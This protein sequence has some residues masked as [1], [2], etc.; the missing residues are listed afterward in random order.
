MIRSAHRNFGSL[1]ILLLGL[2][3]FYSDAAKRGRQHQRELD[4]PVGFIP[5]GEAETASRASGHAEPTARGGR[6]QRARRREDDKPE[7]TTAEKPNTPLNDNL[8]LKW[9]RGKLSSLD[10]Q[11]IAYD[12]RSQCA[13]G[14]DALSG[15]GSS[16][17]H[18]QNLFR[19]LVHIFGRPAGA[20]ELDWILIPTKGN[21]R[22]PSS[23][24]LAA[25][26][27]ARLQSDRP[28]IWRKRIIGI[29]GAS[30][31]FW[32]S[33]QHSDYVRNHPHL[34]RSHWDTIVPLGMHGDG[35][36][37]NKV[38]SLYTFS[39][40]SLIC[41]GKTLDMKF[42]F[43]VIKKT[44]LVQDSLD[45]LMKA[46]AWSLNVILSGETPHVSWDGVRLQGGG[47]PLA[48]GHRGSLCK[49]RGDWE[50][51]TQLFHFGRWDSATEMCPFCLAASNRR[52]RAWSD[53]SDDAWWRDHIRTHQSYIDNLIRCG[54]PLPILFDPVLGVIGLRLSCV[55]VDVLHTLDQGISSHIVANCIWYFAIIVG[56]FGGTNQKER[57][58]RCYEDLKSWYRKPENRK[59]YKVVGK[60]TVER[61]K[62]SGDWPKLK[63]K[64]A[65]TRHLAAYALSLATRFGRCESLD[66]F[67]RLHDQLVIGVAQLLVEFYE[68]ISVESMYLSA[69][70][71]ARLPQLGNDLAKL[72]ARLSTIAFE[73]LQID[74]TWRLWKLSPK[75]HLFLH[76]CCEQT[77]EW[78]N[79]RFWWCYGDEDMIG[80]MIGIAES[81][82]PTTLAAS[83][84]AKW[85]WC[86]YDQVL[87]VDPDE[88]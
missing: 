4:E 86:V 52:D 67:T 21:R 45:H 68:I 38:D 35:G 64:A 66:D 77:I 58:Q 71:K 84:L 57:I 49:V 80:L 73:K 56:V 42:V 60:L 79:P 2:F 25:P 82:H 32:S 1:L 43:T 62:A 55:M 76:L 17:K 33:I 14:L 19:D 53:F 37:F 36:G 28:D 23:C 72:Y 59:L 70:A 15:A 39:W 12:A 44:D 9:A 31:E 18:A 78:G 88:L 5:G 81:V 7:T 85:L 75:L 48:A 50:F 20:P 47:L 51:F 11:S 63:A 61:V 24:V 41:S 69:A 54:R 29:D 16:G 74:P 34:P 87:L 65:A 8:R 40:N 10:L 3:F 6:L 22:T 46:F 83:V 30:R 26:F 27:F 13:H